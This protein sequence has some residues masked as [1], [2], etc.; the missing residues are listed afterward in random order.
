VHRGS[1]SIGA[2]VGE[3]RIDELQRIGWGREAEI[4][5][6]SDGRVL[7]L[8]RRADMREGVERE[9]AALVTAASAGAPVPKV[10]ELTDVA[11]RPGLVLE[12]LEGHDLLAG[13]LSRPW[14]VP[15]VPQVLARV[16]ASL[17]EIVAPASLP[18]LRTDVAGRLRSEL[19]PPDVRAA[20]LLALERLPDGDRLYHGD[21]HPGNVFGTG[22]TWAVIDWKNAARAD[23]AAD[24]ARTQLLFARAWIP[25]WGPRL[26]QQ[27]LSPVRWALYGAYRRAYGR[28]RRVGRSAVAAWVPVL[29]AARLA[30]NIDQDRSAL[31]RLARRGLR[32]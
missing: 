29:A 8:A 24:V 18:E 30:E 31:L 19:V 7:R 11:G 26:A 5:S 3:I 23:P 15:Q 13:L 22:D 17:H 2:V 1:R 14:E 4:F 6:W 28:R 25:G 32:A 27:A 10:Y 16:H 9:R 21:F 20:A 12:R